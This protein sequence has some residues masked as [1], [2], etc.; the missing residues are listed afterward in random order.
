MA[1][2]KN[3]KKTN[4][5]SNSNSGKAQEKIQEKA[6][7]SKEP[8][9][10]N[11]FDSFQVE[12]GEIPNLENNNME[13]KIERSRTQTPT[14]VS[15][16]VIEEVSEKEPNRFDSSRGN[17]ADMVA[18]EEESVG[19]SEEDETLGKAEERSLTPV[20]TWEEMVK[21]NRI[22]PKHASPQQSTSQESQEIVGQ[23]PSQATRGR[24]SQ[25]Q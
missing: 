15:P 16:I 9:I 13:D 21:H 6:S 10:N 19:K 20:G 22:N 24:K 5:T 17:W 8:L 4:S 11:P 3:R 7:K 25:R 18:E 2:S 14:T 12:E 23:G 1:P